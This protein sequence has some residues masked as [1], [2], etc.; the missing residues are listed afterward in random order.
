[1]RSKPEWNSDTHVLSDE[2]PFGDSAVAAALSR[3]RGSRGS[4]AESESV[5]K[6]QGSQ[7]NGN[8]C[9]NHRHTREVKLHRQWGEGA[10][11]P[12]SASAAYSRAEVQ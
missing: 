7:G 8:G 3:R 6:S 2:E 1:A 10:T 4:L 12:A 5:Y 11:A 9:W